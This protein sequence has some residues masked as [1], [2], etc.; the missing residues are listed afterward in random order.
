MGDGVQ[1][2]PGRCTPTGVQVD[3]A[4]A[5]SSR[6]DSTLIELCGVLDHASVPYLRQ[7]TLSLFDQD[8]R[9]LIYDMSGLRLL[10]AAS[11]KV[12]LY[13]ATRAEELEVTVQ[14]TGAVGA[15]LDVL[16][17]AGVAKQLG[18]HDELSWPLRAR[19][20]E[21]VE[22]DKLQLAYRFWPAGLAELFVRLH[23]TAL[24]DPRRAPQRKHIIE[25]CLPASERLAR[26]FAGSG[27]PSVDLT[28]VA[29][30]GLIKAVDG[31]NPG[32]GSTAISPRS[33]SPRRS[34]CPRCMCPGC[35]ASRS[36]S[37][38]GAFSKPD[39][40]CRLRSCPSPLAR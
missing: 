27:E 9:H 21:P 7:V 26:R 38:N 5:L 29:A 39:S 4:I 37:S 40:V 3:L 34:D 12:L 19:Q 31:F 20:R 33:R 28:Q 23:R 2:P 32:R 10:D 36:A 25:Q 15:V 24:D 35:C 16:E 13:L 18:V 6:G 30:L 8:R 1:R 17:L 22:L 14:V 11:V